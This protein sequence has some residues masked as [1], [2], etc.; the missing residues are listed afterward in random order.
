MFV[1][2]G[3]ALAAYLSQRGWGYPFWRPGV[4]REIAEATALPH[5][6]ILDPSNDK[7]CNFAKPAG[8]ASI[9]SIR[10]DENFQNEARLLAGCSRGQRPFGVRH[11]F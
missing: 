2:L 9:S 7:D 4:A 3:V 5:L 8:R 6:T 11:I 1:V 10:R